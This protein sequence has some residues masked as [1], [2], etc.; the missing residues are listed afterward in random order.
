MQAVLR[1]NGVLLTTN[2]AF[3]RA[4]VQAGAAAD[5]GLGNMIA[6]FLGF[7]PTDRINLAEDGLHAQVEVFDGEIPELKNDADI[8]GISGV[9]IGKIW[10]LCEYRIDFSSWFSAGTALPDRRIISLN[11]V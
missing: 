10:L 1:L 7:R 4:V 11:R 8:P 5:A 6:L 3:L 2:N 9:H